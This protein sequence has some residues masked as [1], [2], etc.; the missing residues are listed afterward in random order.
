MTKRSSYLYDNSARTAEQRLRGLEEI[1]DQNTIASLESL[2][3]IEGWS[4]L[5]LGAGAGSIAAWLAARVGP[6]G[7]VL[8]TD[9]EP[10]LLDSNRYQVVQH[11]LETD[12]VPT[13]EFDLVH[14]R[15][16]LIHLSDPQNALKKVYAALKPGAWLVAEESDLSSWR[17]ETGS[18]GAQQIFQSGVAS[19]FEIYKSRGMNPQLGAGL[20][21]SVQAA[22]L[23]VE[24]VRERSRTVRGGSPEASYQSTSAEQ[25][26]QSLLE[27]DPDRKKSL[28]A[29]SNCILDPTL[30]YRS[31][32]TISITATKAQQ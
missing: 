9:I 19:L 26:A 32:S 14:F 4:C 18:L 20:S 25:L 10:R 22:G 1:E 28:L 8:A 24:Q 23:T 16:L 17:F 13:E 27:S 6:Q 29:L 5:E 31:R 15:H 30:S 11:D 21:K 3:S 12:R 2:P 7:S